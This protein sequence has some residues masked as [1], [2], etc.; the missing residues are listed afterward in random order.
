VRDLFPE[1]GEGF[2]AA[3]LHHFEDRS[4]AVIDALLTNALP[5]ALTSLKRN[6]PLPA[7]PAVAA[8]TARPVQAVVPASQPSQPAQPERRNIFD[9]DDLS[10]V[11]VVHGKKYAQLHTLARLAGSR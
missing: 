10:N 3:C 5:A 11:S 4:E 6:M 9:N 7:K 8:A 1:L 2:I